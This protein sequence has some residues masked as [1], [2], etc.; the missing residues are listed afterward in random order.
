M[1]WKR[2]RVEGGED[3]VGNE[4][5]NGLDFRGIEGERKVHLW[6]AC[7]CVTIRPN[8][9]IPATQSYQKQCYRWLI[10]ADCIMSG[11]TFFMKWPQQTKDS[12][13]WF[14]LEVEFLIFSVNDNFCTLVIFFKKCGG[15]LVFPQMSSQIC[16][17]WI[18]NGNCKYG[19]FCHICFMLGFFPRLRNVLLFLTWV[20]KDFYSCKKKRY[21]F[22]LSNCREIS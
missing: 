18:Q 11:I 13:V 2:W 20:R 4:S 8:P 6:M 22:N 5:A 3:Q 14:S 10:K 19:S 17:V 15:N 21:Y 12:N 16:C 1:R 7:V 9:I